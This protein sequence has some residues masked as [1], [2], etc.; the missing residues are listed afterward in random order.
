VTPTA[1][2][3]PVSVHIAS[4][5]PGALPPGAKHAHRSR[6]MYQT[7]V[8][9][10]ADP[11]QCILPEDENREI[12][13][14]KA[15]DNDIM[16][17]PSAGVVGAAVNTVASVPNPNGTLVQKSDTAPYPVHDNGAVYAGITTTGSSSRV[18]VAAYYKA[19]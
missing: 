18:T 11:A 3:L 19:P 13:Y 10:A 16:I 12:A 2:D 7:F 6:G 14:I 1:N 5:D 17:G 15:L 8:L 4:A 9:T